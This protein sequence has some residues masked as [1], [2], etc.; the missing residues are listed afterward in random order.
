MP[1]LPPSMQL[2]PPTSKSQ[3]TPESFIDTLP[4]VNATCDV[5]LTL[6][7]LSKEPGDRRPLG[8]YPDEHFIEEAPRRSITTFQNC[9][10]QISRDIQEQNWGLALP[11]TY[12]D[13]PVIENSVS[14]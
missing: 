3:A 1:N 10:A 8:T 6:W 5:I 14:I 2:P 11:Y 12:L 13:P 7:L 4:P 9:L